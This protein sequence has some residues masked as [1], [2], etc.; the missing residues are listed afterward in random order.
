MT[1]LNKDPSIYVR[2]SVG[3]NLK[4]LSKYM[5]CKILKLMMGWIEISN[6]KVHDDLASEIG[7]F[8]EQKWLVWTIKHALRWLQK[9]N[10]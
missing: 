7:M 10:P 6:I 8:Q 2:K 9:K 4:D 5:P 3:N 1:L